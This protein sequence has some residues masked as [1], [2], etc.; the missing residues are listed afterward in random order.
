MPSSIPRLVRRLRNGSSAQQETA[1]HELFS[2]V[3]L[4]SDEASDKRLDEVAATIAGAGAI[5]TLMHIVSTS[6]SARLLMAALSILTGL[7]GGSRQRADAVAAAGVAPL[8]QLMSSDS[9]DLQWNATRVLVNVTCGSN[10]TT[11][12]GVAAAGPFR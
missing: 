12:D 9:A 11:K 7:A 2:L 10:E 5:P 6:Q 1:A 8:V 3:A 4:A